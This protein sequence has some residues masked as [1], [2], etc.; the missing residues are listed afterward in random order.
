MIGAASSI[1]IRWTI[2]SSIS[3]GRTARA[4][5]ILVRI[6]SVFFCRSSP[7]SNC[8]EVVETP[9][10]TT[11]CRFL[12]PDTPATESS[13]TRV[14]WVSSSPGSAPFWV[15]VTAITGSWMFGY[16][17]IASPE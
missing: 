3:R 1:S 17:L 5:A 7:I 2:G 6:S 10:V 14:T 15:T 4:E 8:I 13:T 11:D 16:C 9:A 12:M